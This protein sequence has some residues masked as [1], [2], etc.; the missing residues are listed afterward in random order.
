MEMKVPL[1]L[2]FATNNLHKFTEIKEIAGEKIIV[3]SLRDIG[4]SDDIPEDYTT[5]EENAAQKAFYIYERYHTD[6]FAD[7]TGLE[8]HALNNEPGVYSARYAGEQC[9]FQDNINKVLGKLKNVTDRRARF[10]TVIALVMEGK[11]T[12]FTGEIA[13][14]IT[15]ERRGNQGFGYDPVFVPDGHIKT[16]AEMEAAEKNGISHRNIAIN[17]LVKFLK[18]KGY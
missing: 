7:D 18:Q 17:K 12:L 6:C 5:I 9:S 10:R 14:R 13:G 3:L 1:K 11:L 4:F 2:I 16:F 15:L 8:I